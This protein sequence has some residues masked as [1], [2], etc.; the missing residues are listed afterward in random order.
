MGYPF[1]DLKR[2]P[3]DLAV[4]QLMPLPLVKSLRSLPIAVD[5]G[6][7]IVVVD[8]PS[9]LAKLRGVAELAAYKVL[10]V[11]APA[12]RIDGAIARLP[13][14]GDPWAVNVPLR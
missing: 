14:P 11:I 13:H 10:I 4:A 7:V 5:A 9:S 8:R 3:V 1:V 6:R 2:F 12:A